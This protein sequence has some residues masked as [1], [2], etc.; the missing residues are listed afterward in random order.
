MCQTIIDI[1]GA[2]GDESVCFGVG[3]ILT[4]DRDYSI[5]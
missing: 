3:G 1:V 5:S 2:S 4:F